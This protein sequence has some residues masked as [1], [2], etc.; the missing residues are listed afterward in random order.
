MATLSTVWDGIGPATCQLL[1]ILLLAPFYQWGH[2]G[3]NSSGGSTKG[4]IL[5][6]KQEQ[7]TR[8]KPPDT[9]IHSQKA[10]LLP[11]FETR[12][13]RCR[14]QCPPESEARPQP[15]EVWSVRFVIP[16][17]PQ[18]E[19]GVMLDRTF[20]EVLTGPGAVQPEDKRVLLLPSL[21]GEAQGSRLSGGQEHQWRIIC[22]KEDSQE[23]G[24]PDH[25]PPLPPMSICSF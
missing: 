22:S 16:R 14:N 4:Q 23:R 3:W 19:E 24:L 12:H 11:S 10:S 21:W 18:A 2:G 9:Q 13:P 25:H 17:R 7:D 20:P 6:K 8:L 5:R 15:D 1:T